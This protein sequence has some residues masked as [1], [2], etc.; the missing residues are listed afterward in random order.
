[1]EEGVSA[2]TEDEGPAAVDETIENTRIN[3]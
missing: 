2:A 3:T 1:M